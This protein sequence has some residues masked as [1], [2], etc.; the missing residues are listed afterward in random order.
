M[1]KKRES[2]MNPHATTHSSIRKLVQYAI[3]A[4]LAC[5]LLTLPA[6]AKSPWRAPP[7]G[8]VVGTVE[9][10]VAAIVTLAHD[11]FLR[12][13]KTD[14]SG[15]FS[16]KQVPYGKYFI[17]AEA[18]G[19]AFGSA[20]TV[21]V[22]APS[23][24]VAR[25]VPVRAS[26]KTQALNQDRFSFHWRDDGSRSGYELTAGINQPPVIHFLEQTLS[27][28]DPSAASSLQYD[29]NIILSN[30]QV[31]WSQEHASRLLQVMKTIPQFIHLDARQQPL[32]P[33]KWILTDRAVVDDIQV[34]RADGGDTITLSTASMVH[35]KP[36]MV[37][38]NG[39]KGQFFSKRL[40]HALVRY[41][42]QDG[43]DEAAVEKILRERFATS[44]MVPDYAALTATTTQEDQ[45]RFTR[46]RPRE[47]IEIV[48]MFEEMP[49]GMHVVKGLN[50]LVRR[51]FG[52]KNPR[53]FC[54]SALAFPA[55]GYI[56]F[57]DGA[58]TDLTFTHHVIL[59]EKSHFMWEF[60]FD[61]KLREAWAKVGGWRPDS[62]DPHGWTTSQTTSFVSSYAHLKN[63]NEDM[64]ESIAGYILD[65][66]LLHS[67]SVAKFE[68]IRDHVM[69]GS[70]YVTQVRS[71]LQFDVL[72][73]FPDYDYPGKIKR[74]DVVV[75][76]APESDKTVTIELEVNTIPGKMDGVELAYMMLRVEG[77]PHKELWLQRKTGSHSVVTGS[78]IIS[79]YAKSGFWSTDQ[80]RLI[81]TVGNTRYQGVHDFGWKMWVNNPLQDS[82]PPRYV[83][84]SL[85][86]A[87]Q[88][89]APVE[90]HALQKLVVS[91]QVDKDGPINPLNDMYAAVLE[92]NSGMLIAAW[93]YYDAKTKTARVEF[94]VTEF[95]ASGQ[96]QVPYI[97]LRDAAGNRAWQY[98]SDS[99]KD[100]PVTSLTVHTSKPDYLPPELDVNKI[101]I[102]AV[103]TN[104]LAPNGETRVRIV[105]YARDDKAG[106]RTLNYSLLDPQG[107]SHNYY[108]THDSWKSRFFKGDPNVWTRY[109]INEVLPVGSAPGRWGLA[110][111]EM[112]DQAHNSK[113]YNFQEVLHFEIAR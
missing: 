55:A 95:Y 72:N 82:T 47:L 32:K 3:L 66:E 62:S 6:F 87:L 111:M 106:I 21:S 7:T 91:W 74:V 14:A 92:K 8:E 18:N 73:L 43:N 17:K 108:Y 94:D 79:K 16:F 89:T 81:D 96:Y 90:G 80:I 58:F 53:F 77:G 59:H 93:G 34:V 15:H 41:I 97:A 69:H 84:H 46:F 113:F 65:P 105:F 23:G 101:S 38:L 112:L 42:T 100:E 37:L 44:I 13:T 99:P 31:V 60:L 88:D 78:L 56:E 29:Y 63:P 68:F 110:K 40:H 20:Q 70:S 85:K 75:E 98:F 25:S 35:A 28:A 27:P 19:Y 71:D 30:E 102:E 2:A 83:P 64:A 1:S 54:V 61:S 36:R 57:V 11:G 22:A 50:Y 109:E 9:G 52:Q 33:S 26:F 103:P 107:I 45:H 48:N 5:N 10:G 86:M 4:L 12:T 67:R 49:R 104:P 24:N 51:A 39:V 76:G